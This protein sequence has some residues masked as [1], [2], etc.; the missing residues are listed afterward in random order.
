[1]GILSLSEHTCQTCHKSFPHHRILVRHMVI[2]EGTR[3]VFICPK[4]DCSRVY[5]EK[6]NLTA[7]IKSYHDG[8]RFLC[9]HVG[10]DRTYASKVQCS[11]FYIGNGFLPLNLQIGLEWYCHV[12]HLFVRSYSAHFLEKRLNNLW[13]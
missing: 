4:E 12:C 9:S 13:V 10:C 11:I 1:M 7:H 3:T 2:H 5:Y 8:K 6:R